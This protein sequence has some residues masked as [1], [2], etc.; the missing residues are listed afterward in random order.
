[1]YCAYIDV[2][3][4]LVKV[5]VYSTILLMHFRSRFVSQVFSKIGASEILLFY[6]HLPQ[7]SVTIRPNQN[8]DDCCCLR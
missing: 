3:Y 4:K 8:K 6:A 2:I 5:L 1:M 7:K